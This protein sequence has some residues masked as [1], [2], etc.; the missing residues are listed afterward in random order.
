MGAAL[1]QPLAAFAQEAAPKV[2]AYLG[3]QS[4]EPLAERVRA[5][6]QGLAET[7][8][9]EGRDVTIEYRWAHGNSDKLPA[10]ASELVRRQ[11]AVIATAGSLAAARAAKAAT[12]SIPIVFEIA[13]EPVEAGLVK[14]LTEPNGNLTGVV[15]LDGGIAALRELTP[16]AARIGVLINPAGNA[17]GGWSQAQA[18]ARI[19]GVRLQGLLATN[20]R[21]FDAAFDTLR[22]SGAG[23]LAISADPVFTAKSEQLAA[24]TLRHKLPAVHESRRFTAAGGL[25]SYIGN[26]LESHRLAGIY[27]GRLLKGEKP[28]E[29]PIQTASKGELVI[30]LKTAKALGLDIPEKL[31]AL[32]AEVIE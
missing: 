22:R 9:V 15:S 23:A 5:F 25:L 6:V 10:L 7:G 2:V 3:A 18:A 4:P 11:P 27:A 32:A 28:T 26:T 13:A 1:V 19:L 31:L 21:E 17:A 30:N 20:E 12:T 14:S 16:R 29:L 8:H 24:L